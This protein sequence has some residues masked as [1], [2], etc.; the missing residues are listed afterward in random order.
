MRW[1]SVASRMIWGRV[2]P[3]ADARVESSQALRVEADDDGRG[4]RS[5]DSEWA[6][7]DGVYKQEIKAPAPFSLSRGGIEGRLL[8]WRRWHVVV[9]HCHRLLPLR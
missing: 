2:L 4:A 9:A 3:V 7:L 6:T 5:T 1:A 8:V